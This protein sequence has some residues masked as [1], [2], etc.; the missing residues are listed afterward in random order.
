MN[1]VLSLATG[2][3]LVLIFPRFNFTWLAPIALTP[4]ILSCAREP[5]GRRRFLNGWAS[6]MVFW[7]VVCTW[8]Q[9]VLEVHG[10]LQAPN[11]QQP[12]PDL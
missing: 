5:D 8:I 1:L 9:F 2:V 3:L 4:L 10:G 12:L 6:G 11:T 7:F